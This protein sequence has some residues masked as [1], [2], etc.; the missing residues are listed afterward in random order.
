MT[1]SSISVNSTR[2]HKKWRDSGQL[3]GRAVSVIY[4]NINP[5]PIY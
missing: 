4:L 2:C 5:S 3:A 1:S